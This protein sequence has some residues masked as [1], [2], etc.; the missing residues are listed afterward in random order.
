MRT[1]LLCADYIC[2]TSTSVAST[3]ISVACANYSENVTRNET[4][5]R[6]S[7]YSKSSQ[8]RIY[9][10][11][12]ALWSKICTRRCNR[13]EVRLQRKTIK[14]Y[15]N[16]PVLGQLRVLIWR[17]IRRVSGSLWRVKPLLCRIPREMARTKRM[18]GRSTW[19]WTW[20][21]LKFPDDVRAIDASAECCVASA[22]FLI[23]TA[24]SCRGYLVR[25]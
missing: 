17:E 15:Q 20:K 18:R 19:P 21:L 8:L 5:L 10:P 12:L 11:A 1:R 24:E 4:S 14:M 2:V 7:N 3:L 9:H 22:T 16:Y 23:S 13:R 6:L 25:W